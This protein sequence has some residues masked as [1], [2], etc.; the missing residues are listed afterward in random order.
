MNLE[1][2][3]TLNPEKY[4]DMGVNYYLSILSNG[5]NINYKASIKYQEG[6]E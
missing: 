2:L 6:H 3:E 1:K 5:T 4:N